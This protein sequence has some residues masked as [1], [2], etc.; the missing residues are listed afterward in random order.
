MEKFCE[1]CN[2]LV[3]KDFEFCP[4]CSNPL[5]DKA[6]E[7]EEKKS[8]NAQLIL[9]ATLIKETNDPETL[10]LLNKYVKLLKKI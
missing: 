6:K 9:I 8:V 7:L 2:N 5:T 4:F 10:L 3:E 1:N